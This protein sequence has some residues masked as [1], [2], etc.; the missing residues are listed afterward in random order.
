MYDTLGLTCGPSAISLPVSYLFRSVTGI[1]SLGA[2]S[3]VSTLA[4]HLDDLL[5]RD[6]PGALV[7]R[8]HEHAGLEVDARVLDGLG[9]IAGPDTGATDIE[10]HVVACPGCAYQS[11]RSRPWT[12]AVSR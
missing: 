8:D 4:L 12:V 11:G 7:Q 2:D 10:L 9:A 5:E 1:G 6:E 3:G